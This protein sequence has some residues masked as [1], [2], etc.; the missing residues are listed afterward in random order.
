MR[1][2]DR[3]QSLQTSKAVGLL[4]KKG[5]SWIWFG[6]FENSN[7][8]CLSSIYHT[9]G[10]RNRKLKGVNCNANLPHH[11]GRHQEE[12]VEWDGLDCKSISISYLFSYRFRNRLK[13]LLCMEEGNNC[14]VD[15]MIRTAVARE[16][17]DVH[18]KNS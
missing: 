15:Q 16:A 2:E 6:I 10:W 7:R 14:D 18:A 17:A 4:L 9:T 11:E 5:G 12:L 8:H 1:M 3:V 13:V